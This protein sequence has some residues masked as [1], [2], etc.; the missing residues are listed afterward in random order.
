M[1]G[2]TGRTSQK[3]DSV[4]VAELRRQAREL[5]DLVRANRIGEFVTLLARDRADIEGLAAG[6]TGP[7]A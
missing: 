7:E 4:A 1:Q 2:N 3:A 5:C 6:L